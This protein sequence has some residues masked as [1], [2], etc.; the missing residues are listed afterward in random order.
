MESLTSN[1]FVIAASP[2]CRNPKRLMLHYT[3]HSN[4]DFEMATTKK[5]TARKTVTRARK[6]G[7]ARKGKAAK[8]AAVA[9][10]ELDNNSAPRPKSVKARLFAMFKQAKGDQAK[11][12]ELAAKAKINKFTARKQ[13]YI[14]SRIGALKVWKSA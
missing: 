12:R 10:N 5:A 7:T 9:R 3:P 4:G 11:A 2:R 1:P 8:Q 6:A 13:L 14:M